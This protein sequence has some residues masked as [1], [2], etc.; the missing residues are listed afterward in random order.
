MK[1]EYLSNVTGD[2]PWEGGWHV[3]TLHKKGATAKRRMQLLLIEVY[4]YCIIFF[5]N[6]CPLLS[7]VFAGQHATHLLNPCFD[8]EKKGESMFWTRD[9]PLLYILSLPAILGV[10]GSS[11]TLVGCSVFFQS[12]MMLLG[13]HGV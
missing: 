11:E 7:W 9:V 8:H 4:V 3:S 6:D 1:S 10:K 13:R 5:D 2:S 12:Y